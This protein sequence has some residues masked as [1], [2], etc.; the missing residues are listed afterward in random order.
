MTTSGA[1]HLAAGP[2]AQS[3]P[4]SGRHPGP[5]PLGNWRMNLV[6]FHWTTTTANC[7][8]PS[9]VLD[10]SCGTDGRLR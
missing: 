2:A 10:L 1:T 8:R 9:V 5:L 4:A 7:A 3:A 6:S